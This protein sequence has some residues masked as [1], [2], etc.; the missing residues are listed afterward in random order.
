M[1]KASS[2]ALAVSLM[3][4]GSGSPKLT[5]QGGPPQSLPNQASQV[6]Q[7]IV[8]FD[9]ELEV[10][11]EDSPTG[12]RLLHFLN[13]GT[14]RLQLRFTDA[15]LD[16]QSGTRVKVR[17]RLQDTNTLALSASGDVQMLSLPTVNTFGAQSTLVMLINFNDN[18]SQPYAPSSAFTT[19]FQ[20]TSD[21][22]RENSYQQTWLTGAVYGW[23]TISA[24]SSTCD[25]D[26][27]ASL[28]D[29]AAQQAGANLANFPRR[30]YAFPSTAS[31]GW[32]G[33]GSV[34]GNPSRAWINGN[35]TLKVVGHEFGHN[36]GEYHSHSRPCE[37][38]GCTT[39]EY[40]D[41]HDIM[42][43]TSSGHLN[44]F[45]KER[46]GWLN[47]GSSPAIQTITQSGDYHVNAMEPTGSGPKGLKIPIATDGSGLRTYY[48]IEAQTG[49]G[50]DSGNVPGVL[51]HSGYE[52][53]GDSSYQI[54]LDPA[55][56]NFDA[57]L[58]PGQTFSDAVAGVMITTDGADA[59]GAT[60][61]ITVTGPACAPAA[62]TIT[63]SP[64]T[65]VSA[66]AGAGVSYTLTVRN[67]DSSTCA[68]STFGLSSLVPSGW[69]GAFGV[70]A[71]S[72]NPGASSNTS[73]M[74][75]SSPAASGQYTFQAGAMRPTSS[76]SATGTINVISSL[77]VTVAAS[78]AKGGQYQMS[79]TVRANGAAAAGV[80]VTFTIVDP[81]GGSR[82]LS[83]TTNTSGVATVAFR[84]R[85][86]DPTGTY[87]VQAL[88]T[89]G[90]ITNTGSV[91]FSVR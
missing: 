50:F 76:A 35:Y 60:V 56:S 64:G 66:A 23:F 28:A 79:A 21:Y 49:A 48:Y 5:A 78:S 83:G 8:E 11:Y 33:L 30:I 90:S 22:Y 73:M 44:A 38:A 15:P 20:T 45:Q 32:W 47:Y 87:S 59:N 85:K 65:M 37:A 84:P 55:T 81:M 19:T 68:A 52:G 40:G 25:T 86:N 82:V 2:L 4:V 63:M 58:D 17:G 31:C 53:S 43:Q 41:D 69:T 9:G 24:N 34:G 39:V 67:N 1:H 7:G 6:A 88:A 51:V 14:R 77:S 26:T 42:G 72:L 89:L 16:W 27:W 18:A 71:V 62:P 70:A 3:F 13:T 12:A 57:V 46:L 29:Q 75:T 36:L 74:V 10:Q 91:T 54:D 61:T 80:A